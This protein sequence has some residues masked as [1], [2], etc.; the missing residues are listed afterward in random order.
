MSDF[1][2]AKTR[3][4]LTAIKSIISPGKNVTCYTHKIIQFLPFKYRY[5]C[6]IKYPRSCWSYMFES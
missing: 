1:G 5:N 4:Q 2:I 3:L 6:G